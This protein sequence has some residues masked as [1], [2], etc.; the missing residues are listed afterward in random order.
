MPVV[1]LIRTAR[2]T[3]QIVRRNF[4]ITLFYNVVAGV[5]AITGVMNPLIAAILMPLSGL[6]TIGF[7]TASA[8]RKV[9]E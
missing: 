1:E 4:A 9:G 3:M 2:R 7:A 5:L 6:T 8:R